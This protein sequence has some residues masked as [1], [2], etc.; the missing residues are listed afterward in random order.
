M[1]NVQ[2]ESMRRAG[3]YLLSKETRRERR[4]DKILNWALLVG[5]V[6]WGIVYISVLGW[7]P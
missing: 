1:D 4:R 7:K 5:F 2:I 6:L 3:E